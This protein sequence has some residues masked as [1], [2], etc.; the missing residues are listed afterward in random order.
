MAL[1]L[2]DLSA[3]MPSMAEGLAAFAGSTLVQ[4]A[5]GT[6]F[7]HWWEYTKK[8]NMIGDAGSLQSFNASVSTQEYTS[9]H[10]N[11]WQGVFYVVLAIVFVLNVFCL[12]YILFK[13][14]LVTDFTEPLNLFTLAV[15]SPPSQQL[16]GSCG[17]GPR[18]RDL[19]VP[20]RIAYAPSANHY[21]FQ[22]ASDSMW[23]GGEKGENE[24]MM[25]SGSDRSGRVG[26]T[27]KRLSSAKG[28]F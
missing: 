3:Y 21:F 14:G 12:G 10:I 7:V 17:G 5:I 4:A 6:P 22:E 9:G 18:K 23:K 28:W 8:G 11:N 1:Q 15:N 19:M 25:H 16:K 13:S 27:Y 2:P 26:H 20:W 24:S